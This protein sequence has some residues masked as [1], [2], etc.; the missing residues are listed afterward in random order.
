MVKLW[1]LLLLVSFGYARNACIASSS[2]SHEI[3]ALG[4]VVTNYSMT[5][6]NEDIRELGME[7][8]SWMFVKIQEMQR[9]LKRKKDTVTLAGGDAVN[10]VKGLSHLGRKCAL[11]GRVGIDELGKEYAEE[12]QSHKIKTLFYPE[13]FP[14]GK[15][16][17]LITPDGQKTMRT[18]FSDSHER[19]KLALDPHD[20]G[21]FLSTRKGE[22]NYL[23]KLKR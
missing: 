18:F 22:H 7:K 23:R 9:L 21:D 19:R 14:T 13:D 8:G 3:L 2:H 15:T 5:V 12:L 20:R 1:C 17:F 4:S 11:I 16:L 10:V 6:S